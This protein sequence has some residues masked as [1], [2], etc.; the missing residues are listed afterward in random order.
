MKKELVLLSLVLL[1][2]CNQL[3]PSAE[4]A[5]LPTVDREA[6]NKTDGW[7]SAGTLKNDAIPGA[8]NVYSVNKSD[9]RVC[10]YMFFSM[11]VPVKGFPGTMS[12]VRSVEVTCSKANDTK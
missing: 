11:T 4:A 7:V 9:G 3:Q 10:E 5:K 2:G 8:M 12:D 1:T 6:D